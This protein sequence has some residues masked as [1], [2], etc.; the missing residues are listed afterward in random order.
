LRYLLAT[1]LTTASTTRD[2][3]RRLDEL[4][5]AVTATLTLDLAYNVRLFPGGWRNTILR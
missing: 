5:V 1:L 2:S 3:Q 4:L